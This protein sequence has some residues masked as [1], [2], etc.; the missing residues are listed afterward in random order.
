MVSIIIEI[1][2]FSVLWWWLVK[3]ATVFLATISLA[4]DVFI[5]LVI[6]NV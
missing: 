2:R 3:V 5:I 4:E 1:F 6:L